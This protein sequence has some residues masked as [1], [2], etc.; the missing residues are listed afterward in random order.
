MAA[1]TMHSLGDLELDAGWPSDARTHYREALEVFRRSGMER[2]I[3][4]CLGGLSAAAAALGDS[5][6]AARLWGALMAL[7]ERLGLPLFEHERQRY[8][9]ST[10]AA[11]DLHPSLVAEGMTWSGDEAVGY[12]LGDPPI[13]QDDRAHKRPFHERL[14]SDEP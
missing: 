8:E 7:E 4:N 11:Q 1:S 5:S 12:A 2:E 9:R 10:A 14:L 13:S 6:R 3:G